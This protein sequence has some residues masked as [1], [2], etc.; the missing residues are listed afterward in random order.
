MRALPFSSARASLLS[1]KSGGDDFLASAAQRGTWVKLS[2]N[3]RAD[4]LLGLS[5]RGLGALSSFALIWMISQIFGADVLGLY[6][7]GVTGVALLALFGL[8]GND[9]LLVRDIGAKIKSGLLADARAQFSSARKFVWMLS[10][11]AAAILA[12]FA[13]P[14]SEYVIGEPRLT[15]YLLLLAPAVLLL[16]SLRLTNSFLRTN[17]SV[18]ASQTL[19]GVFYTTLATALLALVWWSGWAV[20]EWFLILAYGGSLALAAGLSLMLARR[21]AISWPEGGIAKLKPRAGAVIAAAQ[22]P[23]S[24]TQWLVLLIITMVISVADSGIYRTA[25]QFCMLFQ[26][27]ATS[28]NMMAGPH[29]SRAVAGSDGADVHKTVR[30]TGLIGLSL[31][32]V[33]ALIVLFAAE[34]LLQLFGA[35]FTIATG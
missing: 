29:L 13:F 22:S 30:M 19:E 18:L 25:F 15:R 4:L 28:F 1:R 17:G 3:L 2:G 8:L 16:A 20:P 9:V 7:L 12:I 32:A 6:Q 14:F 5:L 23:T 31:C 11:G 10:A 27:V 35:E 24:I 33:P 21:L 34:W 26:L